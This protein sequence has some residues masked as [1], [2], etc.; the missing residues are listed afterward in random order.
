VEEH[1]PGNIVERVAKRR[2]I[3]A[4]PHAIRV[5]V[6]CIGDFA[7]GTKQSYRALLIG[8]P[9]VLEWRLP[10][11]GGA[12]PRELVEVRDDLWVKRHD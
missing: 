1:E 11:R 6:L 4:N 2:P 12:E 3:D 10:R 8:P 9:H 7:S 5:H